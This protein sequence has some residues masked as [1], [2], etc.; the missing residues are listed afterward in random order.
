MEFLEEVVPSMPRLQ[1]VDSSCFL[2]LYVLNEPQSVDFYLLQLLEPHHVFIELLLTSHLL[3]A[4]AIAF[5]WSR[6]LENLWGESALDL[7]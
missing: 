2:G 7:F 5:T 6:L 4:A 1:I 3:L